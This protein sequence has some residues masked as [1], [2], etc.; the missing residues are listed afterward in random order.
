MSHK[1]LPQTAHFYV[2]TT[3]M[4]VLSSTTKHKKNEY[5]VRM[6]HKQ[7]R[8]KAATIFIKIA[9]ALRAESGTRTRDLFITN[10]LLYQLSYFGSPFLNCGA[11]LEIKIQVSK[12]SVGFLRKNFVGHVRPANMG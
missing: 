8:K 3:I 9:A 11:K 12:P 5:V 4:T 1:N 7:F 2:L 10:E 6:P